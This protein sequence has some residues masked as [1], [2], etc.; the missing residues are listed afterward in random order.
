MFEASLNDLDEDDPIEDVRPI[1]RR[2]EAKEKKEPIV[3]DLVDSEDDESNKPIEIDSPVQQ[4]RRTTRQNA[5]SLG[6]SVA[7]FGKYTAEYPNDGS[8]GAAVIT[9]KD[10]DCLEPGEMLNDQTID[11]YMKKISEEEFS[12]P[13]DKERCLVM[14]SYFYQK[15]TQKSNGTSNMAER[16]DQA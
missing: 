16:K 14:N 7:R 11:F 6:S 10:L 2:R 3:V 4:R 12:S 15:L 13:E 8:K 1:G 9:T 5:G